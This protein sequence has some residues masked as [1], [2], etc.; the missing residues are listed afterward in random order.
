[1]GKKKK[2]TVD[3]NKIEA[4]IWRLAEPLALQAGAELIDVEYLKEAG[5]W[6]LRLY[7]D[8]E[9]PVDHDLCEAV[10]Q[11]M[12]AALDTAD[13]IEQSYF[14]E[15]SSPGLERPLKRES[16]FARFSGRKV[17][18]KLYAPINGQKEFQGILQGL[19]EGQLII[20]QDGKQFCFAEDQ[21]AKAFLW[22]D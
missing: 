11:L 15:V 12:S 4:E 9:P 18:V 14:L 19:K 21:V 7:I 16:D 3:Y 2:V 13:L 5:N 10:S 20:E 1:M 22:L 8:R 17:G 6:F